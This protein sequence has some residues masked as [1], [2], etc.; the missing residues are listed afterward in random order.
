LNFFNLLSILTAGGVIKNLLLNL[1]KTV[2]LDLDISNGEFIL[3]HPIKNI[4]KFNIP[5]CTKEPGIEVV[6]S[7][8]NVENLVV[9]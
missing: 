3:F 8:A 2:S 9:L 6:R 5:S 1:L 7:S 4:T